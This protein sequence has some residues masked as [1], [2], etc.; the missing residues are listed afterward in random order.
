MRH[1]YPFNQEPSC[2]PKNH[3]CKKI[4]SQHTFDEADDGRALIPRLKQFCSASLF[5]CFGQVSS[6]RSLSMVCFDHENHELF[7]RSF[8]SLTG[9]P[10]DFETWPSPL[11]GR[12]VRDS[13]DARP[14]GLNRSHP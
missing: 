9:H 2:R 11:R 1:F 12:A 13:L 3:G 14:Y 10:F 4:V 7:R 5:D 6:S 8:L